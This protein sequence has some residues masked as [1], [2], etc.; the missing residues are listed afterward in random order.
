MVEAGELGK[1]DHVHAALARLALRDKSRSATQHLA[2]QRGRL[3]L[4]KA[5]RI[6]GPFGSVDIRNSSSDV[7]L[8]NRLLCRL[9]NKAPAPRDVLLQP[10]EI[11]PCGGIPLA[12]PER[13]K[14]DAPTMGQDQPE[15]LCFFDVDLPT[16]SHSVVN[17]LSGFL[18]TLCNRD[19]DQRLSGLKRLGFIL[20]DDLLDVP[21]S[22]ISRTVPAHLVGQAGIGINQSSLNLEGNI[23]TFDSVSVDNVGNLDPCGPNVLDPLK[24]QV[25]CIFF[26]GRRQSALGVPEDPVTPALPQVTKKLRGLR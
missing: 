18:I 5:D 22:V 25:G 9:S 17:A 10:R 24:L 4:N 2:L 23:L 21:A 19:Q 16:T 13:P 7:E 11:R 8:R 12:R 20:C 15:P 3:R 1:F 6:S 26:L 14:H